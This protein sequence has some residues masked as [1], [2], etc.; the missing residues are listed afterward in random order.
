MTAKRT[1]PLT[2]NRAGMVCFNLA[3]QV[4]I[5]STLDA[6][7]AKVF[8]KGH[9]EKDETPDQTAKRELEEEAG[10]IATPL[11]KIGTSS[12]K[13]DKEQVVVEWWAGAAV[14]I[15]PRDPK[16]EYEEYDFREPEW[17]DPHMA[18]D[19]LGFED[20]KVMLKRALCWED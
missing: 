14:R 11:F 16:S 1:T 19:I 5:V 13:V 18:L 17:V 12:Y 4:L 3:G 10:I 9:I 20:L 8:P 15:A 7:N 6:S 2:P